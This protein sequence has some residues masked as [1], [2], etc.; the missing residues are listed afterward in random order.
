MRACFV[1]SEYGTSKEII[2]E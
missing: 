1:F 2:C